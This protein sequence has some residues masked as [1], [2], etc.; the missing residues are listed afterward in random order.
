M[1]YQP[2]LTII[3]PFNCIM[4]AVATLIGFSVALGGFAFTIPLMLAMV[5]AFLICG[6]GQAIN[7]YFDRE[8]DKKTRYFSW[9]VNLLLPLSLGISILS[10]FFRILLGGE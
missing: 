9:S 7:D 10:I 6:A 5:S 1:N 4:A 8:I 2:Y 3:R